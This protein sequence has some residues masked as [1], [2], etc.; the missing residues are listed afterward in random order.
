[1]ITKENLNKPS[2]PYEQFNDKGKKIIYIENIQSKH[3]YLNV[4]S[5]NL[6]HILEE[7]KISMKEEIIYNI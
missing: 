4:S 7:I 6:K 3:Y 2:L 5:K 1:M